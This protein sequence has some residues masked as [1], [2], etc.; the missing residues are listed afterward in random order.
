[1][2][3]LN[4][5]VTEFAVLHDSR[6]VP[7]NAKQREKMHGKYPYYGANGLVDHV[8]DYLFDGQYTLLAED[9]GYFD[10]PKRGVAYQA[11][12]KFWVNNHV[13]ILQPLGDIP[14]RFLRHALNAF[15]W[16][17]Y[18]GGTT[19]LKLTQGGLQQA[20]IALPPLPEQRRIVAK[21]DSLS[22]KSRRARDNLDHLPRLVEKY[23]QAILAAAFSGELSPNAA[24]WHRCTISDVCVLIDGDRGPNY[25]KREDYQTSGYCLFLSTKNV[26][27]HGFDFSE[28]QFLSEKKHRILHKGTLSRGD[29]VITTRGT[30]GNVACYAPDIP[31]DV[32]RINSG[33]LILRPNQRIGGEYL[34]WYIR[35]PLFRS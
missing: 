32:V 6:R 33:M 16:M 13:H 4:A 12:G 26:R 35:S 30:I 11:S 24:D 19:R 20:K 21:I 14:N 25:P 23:K 17:P 8:N 5:P 22:E 3:G 29:V 1:M 9:G 34:S 18:V 15:N 10:D 7:L 28:C 2:V 31:Y 27:P